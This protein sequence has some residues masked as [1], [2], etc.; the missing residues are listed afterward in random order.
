MTDI[1]PNSDKKINDFK[2]NYIQRAKKLLEEHE[3]TKSIHKIINSIHIE[4]KLKYSLSTGKWNVNRKPKNQ[5]FDRLNYFHKHITKENVIK[6]SLDNEPD[7][8][9][10]KE[11]DYNEPD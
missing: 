7:L 3:E 6:E 5:I 8:A 10:T 9:L 4:D 1:T 2:L 11:T